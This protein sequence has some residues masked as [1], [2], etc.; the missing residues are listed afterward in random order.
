[1]FIPTVILA[2]LL[3]TI[4]LKFKFASKI[5]RQKYKPINNYKN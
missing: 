3:V 1:M 2:F 5:N 4:V